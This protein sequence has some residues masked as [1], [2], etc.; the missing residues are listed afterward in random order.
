[1]LK[2]NFGEMIMKKLLLL[3][4]SMLFV[5]DGFAHMPPQ[6]IFTTCYAYDCEQ[7]DMDKLMASLVIIP[8]ERKEALC[9]DL[10]ALKESHITEE[11]LLSL[12]NID[13]NRTDRAITSLAKLSLCE[14][15]KNH[16]NAL[17][18]K[19]HT[20]VDKE[21]DDER[22]A[23][24]LWSSIFIVLEVPLLISIIDEMRKGSVFDRDM[25][26]LGALAVGVILGGS[27]SLSQA[28][29]LNRTLRNREAEMN[30]IDVLIERIEKLEKV[31]NA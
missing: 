19:N 4:S 14:V 6:S 2:A 8:R 21:C 28:Y 1:M 30:K 15:L 29:T 16:K 27:F 9:K 3:L 7:V 20:L 26:Q 24:V 18:R 10:L 12:V 31:E 17:I 22:Y 23:D 13:Y 25:G 11:R 5:T